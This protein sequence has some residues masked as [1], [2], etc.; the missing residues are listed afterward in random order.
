MLH[1]VTS[2]GVEFHRLVTME[3]YFCV[4]PGFHTFNLIDYHLVPGQ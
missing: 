3:R 1:L 2:G 4:S